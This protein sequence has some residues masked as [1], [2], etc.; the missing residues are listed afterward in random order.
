MLKNALSSEQI[1]RCCLFQAACSRGSAFPPTW[2]QVH[3][4]YIQ[5][6]PSL[7]EGM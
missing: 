5:T 1:G 4:L 2:S 3:Q 7:G 6:S